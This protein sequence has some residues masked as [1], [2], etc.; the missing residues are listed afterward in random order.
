MTPT[1]RMER[2]ATLRIYYSNGQKRVHPEVSRP[3]SGTL[4]KYH[5]YNTHHT[6]PILAAFLPG[7]HDFGYLPLHRVPD[8]NEGTRM[9]PQQTTKKLA[10]T[11]VTAYQQRVSQRWPRLGGA[12]FSCGR[13]LRPQYERPQVLDHRTIHDE[14]SNFFASGF[15]KDGNVKRL[16]IRTRQMAIQVDAGRGLTVTYV[17]VTFVWQI[18]GYPVLGGYPPGVPVFDLAPK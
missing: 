12:L 9:W 8:L 15:V 16:V 5:Y 11:R 1:A 3:K 18:L 2:F 4:R 14:Q 10:Q 7:A 17:W 13:T 6:H